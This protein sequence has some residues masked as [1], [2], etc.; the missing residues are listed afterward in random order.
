[1]KYDFDMFVIGAGSGGVRIARMA[2]SMGKKVGVAEKSDLGGTCVNVGCIPKKLFS[3]SAHYS[4]DLEDAKSYGWNFSNKTFDWKK[5]VSNKDKEIRRLNII[6]KNLLEGAGAKIFRGHAELKDDKTVKINGKLIS[7]KVI[8][9]A[10]G[11]Q[12][13]IPKFSGNESVITSNDAF[14]LEKLPSKVI[15]VGGGYIAVEFASIFNGLGCTTTQLYRKNL[16]L[17]GFDD[18]CRKIIAEQMV[19]KGVNLKFNT[20]IIKI[21]REEENLIAHTNNNQQLNVDCIMYATGRVPNIEGLCLEEVGIELNNDKAVIV[22]ENYE[23]N[24]N[25]IFALGDVTDRV[26]LTPVALAEAMALLSYLYGDKKRK[27][28]YQFI[29]SAVFGNPNLA[30]VGFTE[31]EAKE[32]FNDIEVYESKFSP[33]KL[34]LTENCEKCYLKLIV[35]CESDKIVGA[36]MVGHDAGESIQAIAIAIKAGA[37]KKIFDETIGIHPTSAEEWVTMREA[38]GT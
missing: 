17:R 18:D 10:T 24:V 20:D 29:P 5:L 33:L 32:K 7:A 25:G 8:V 4:E 36:H 9:I 38:R 30:T 3:Y 12:P 6:Y 22:N 31:N 1:M 16:F 26:N 35:E 15:V 28:N 19:E 2:A 37:T 34:S 13:Y 21:C 27:V 11:G 23:T 14:F